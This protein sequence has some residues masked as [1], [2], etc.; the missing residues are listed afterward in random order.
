MMKN[1]SV[2]ER[3]VVRYKEINFPWE[4]MESKSNEYIVPLVEEKR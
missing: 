1:F 3:V 4:V 2:G